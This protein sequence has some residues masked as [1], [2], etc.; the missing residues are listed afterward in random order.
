MS[1]GVFLGLYL[2]T[3]LDNDYIT[4]T[5]FIISIVL[6]CYVLLL[7]YVHYNP[8]IK[9]RLIEERISIASNEKP[10]IKIE[11][12]N[13]TD[14]K[15]RVADTDAAMCAYFPTLVKSTPYKLKKMKTNLK[16]VGADS[17]LE[18]KDRKEIEL[19]YF[20]KPPFETLWFKRVGILFSKGLRKHLIIRSIDHEIISFKRYIYEIIMYKIFGDKALATD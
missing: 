16:I 9:L 7:L 19:Q 14:D 17:A 10:H 1:I 18:P 2:K 11:V 8:P 5:K 12:T 6:V 20:D 15:I 4:S 13:Y 3:H